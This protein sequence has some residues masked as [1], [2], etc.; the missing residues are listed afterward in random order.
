M[1][2]ALTIL[3]ALAYAAA[4]FAIAFV[5]DRKGMGRQARPAYTLSLAV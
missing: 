4:L 3:V 5:V 2:G 1:G